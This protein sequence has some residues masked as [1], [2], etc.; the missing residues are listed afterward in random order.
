MP[1]LPT[2][3]LGNVVALSRRAAA[4]NCVA[5]YEGRRQSVRALRAVQAGEELTVRGSRQPP[6]CA[7]ARPCAFAC[8]LCVCNDE[9]APMQLGYIDLAQPVMRRRECVREAAS[10]AVSAGAADTTRPP[11]AAPCNAPTSS[12][13]T[14][15]AASAYVARKGGTPC[16]PSRPH[17][18]VRLQA[19][20]GPFPPPDWFLS[21]V[22]LR[23]AAPTAA[24]LQKPAAGPLATASSVGSSAH[25]TGG[26]LAAAGTHAAEQQR[27]IATA[28]DSTGGM[29]GAPVLDDVPSDEETGVQEAGAKEAGAQKLVRWRR[30]D[31]P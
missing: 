10:P 26:V 20:H 6:A 15:R 8:A 4:P 9:R 21:A 30:S 28:L 7:H 24:T 25:G 5:V 22:R 18:R 3:P 17:L 16:R 27:R 2:P 12:P 29:R 14:A 19:L 23:Q 1:P 13:V 11:R 31:R